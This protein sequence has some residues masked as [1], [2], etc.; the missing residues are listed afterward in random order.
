MMKTS[1]R[2]PNCCGFTQLSP[3]KV[4]VGAPR[5]GVDDT[6]Q[7][8]RAATRARRAAQARLDATPC[9]HPGKVAL[10]IALLVLEPQALAYAVSKATVVLG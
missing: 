9:A 10:N 8:E 5:A 1:D 6:G 4:G 2:S 3:V 7:A